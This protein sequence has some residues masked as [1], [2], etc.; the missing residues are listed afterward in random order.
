MQSF[1]ILQSINI[2]GYLYFL[3]Y[4]KNIQKYGYVCF[5]ALLD[6]FFGSKAL[7][8]NPDVNQ[9]HS[10]AIMS[11]LNEIQKYKMHYICITSASDSAVKMKD[12]MVREWT[13]GNY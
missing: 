5:F 12:E 7:I 10:K 2:H 6:Q 4:L 13:K 11:S 8:S 9:H 3:Y 1:Y